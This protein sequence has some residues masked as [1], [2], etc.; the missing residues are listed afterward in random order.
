MSE[1]LDSLV[2]QLIVAPVDVILDDA[3]AEITGA[4]VS[5]GL[6]VKAAELLVALPTL[7]VTM[8]LNVAPLSP[9]TVVGVV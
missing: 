2:V 1:S 8:H 6:T 5:G 7:L 4:V 3:T 9:A